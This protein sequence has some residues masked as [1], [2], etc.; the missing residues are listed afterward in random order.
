MTFL[1]WLTI[2]LFAGIL[3]ALAIPLSKH[4]A[5]VY[6]G[7]RTFLD[8]LFGR[9]ERLLYRVMR[10]D[11]DRGQDWKAYA[12][13][14]IVFSLAGWL[15]VVFLPAYAEVVGLH[16]VE[17]DGV[18]FGAVERD[19]QHDFVV[20][21]EHELAV[22]RRRD[23]DELFQPD[24]WADGS[25]L[26]LRWGRDRRRGR[27]DPRD[28]VAERQEPGEFLAGHRA[29]GAVCAD[30][31]LVRGRAGAGV[32]GVD[33]ELLVVSARCMGSRRLGQSIAMGP[34]ASQEAIKLL[35]TNGGGFFNTNSAHPF[36]N[37]TGVHEPGRDADGADHPGGAGVHVWPDDRQSP[38]GLRDLRRR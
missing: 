30:A 17:P 19:V 5:A 20:L 23:D 34:V 16:G 32:P 1:G 3:T 22:L 12:K 31:D 24:G 38:A 14:L 10:V 27:V 4:M 36:E 25:E 26:P 21:D 11:P 37:P 8:P 6:T 29:H 9:L 2:F 28:R 15:L 35:G 33:P 7:G 18:S 13:S